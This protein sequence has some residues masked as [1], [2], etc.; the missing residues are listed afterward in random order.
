MCTFV[1]TIL[2][3]LKLVGVKL[4]TWLLGIYRDK[5]YWY[6]N[7]YYQIKLGC[8][9]RFLPS[10]RYIEIKLGC[11]IRFFLLYLKPML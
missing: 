11:G 5:T 10:L 9:I 3:M 1:C 2:L 8:G 7:S 4:R 6:G